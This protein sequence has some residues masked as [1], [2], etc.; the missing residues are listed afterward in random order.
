MFSQLSKRA[1]SRIQYGIPM[2]F[3][4]GIESMIRAAA[5]LDYLYHS[6]LD[7]Y[8]SSDFSPGSAPNSFEE[9]DIRS[10]LVTRFLARSTS[11]VITAVAL[12]GILNR[13]YKHFA[14]TISELGFANCLPVDQGAD[15]L[16]KR[17]SEISAHRWYRNKVFGHTSFAAPKSRTGTDTISLQY[18]SLLYYSGVLLRT[19]SER[20]M[21][22]FEL[23]GGGYVIDGQLPERSRF[24]IPGDRQNILAHYD[25]WELMFLN[26]LK[27]IPTEVLKPSSSREGTC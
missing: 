27:E 3:P 19:A 15:A 14:T 26:V 24:S 9:R 18:S 6:E 1:V 7:D 2:P 16:R 10:R 25:A 8:A 11:Y 13:S 17:K 12:D 23:G 4:L 5:I 22:Y 21:S 20:G